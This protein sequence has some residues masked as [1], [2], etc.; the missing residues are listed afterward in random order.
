MITK[1]LA[2]ASIA[3][4]S[5][6][7]ALPG[8]ATTNDPLRSRQWGL[9]KIQAEQAWSSATGSNIIIAIVDTGVDFNHPDLD[10]K[11]IYNSDADFVEPDGT[12]KGSPKKGRK[13]VQDGAQDANGHGTHVAGIAG[14]ETNNGEGVAGVAPAAKILPVRVLDAGG[15]GST[16]Q[17]AK[18]I[19]YAVD[20]GAHVIN[21]SLGFLSG[22]GEV[23]NL[24]GLLD[25]VH[26]AI[27][28]AHSNGVVVV[29]AAGND[30]FPL[31]SEPGASDGVL[32]VGATDGNDLR[33]S[34]SNGDA[35]LLKN[36][37]VAPGGAGS[38]RCED[39]LDIWS[40]IL[41]GS[42]LDCTGTATLTGRQFIAGYDTLAGTSMAAP[43]VSGVA[44]LLRSKGL[45]REATIRCILASADDLGAP[46]H[47]P[48][49]GHG[50]LNA[51]S[52]V[53]CS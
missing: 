5:F 35:T 9:D 34:Y 23:A 41:P 47:D 29:V 49:F 3:A 18:G 48:V 14:A 30:T 33:A 7:I 8:A 43:H 21:L 46:G 37:L 12:C 36:Y 28:Y 20:K 32:C 1:V 44:A 39:D 19:R 2:L 45:D 52:A 15:S 6:G 50:R 22:V 40:T 10:A 31:C 27:A 11:L 4:L 16:D 53:Q 42:G 24:L 17:V 51:A 38:L 13:C 26:D 25:P